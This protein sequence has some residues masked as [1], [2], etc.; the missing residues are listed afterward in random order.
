MRL[1]LAHLPGSRL[2]GSTLLA[3]ATLA[4][5]TATQSGVIGWGETV[6]NSAWTRDRYQALA[7]GWEHTLGLRVDGTLVAWGDNRGNEPRTPIGQCSD[8]PP[9][10]AG[11]TYIAASGGIRH[12]AALRSD[13]LILVWGDTQFEPWPLQLL[14]CVEISAGT[15]HTLARFTDGSVTVGGIDEPPAPALPAGVVYVEISAGGHHSLARH[16]D[17][18]VVAWGCNS[19]GQLDV[20]ALPPGV[21]YTAIA[22]DDGNSA[23]C[24][25]DGRAVQWGY[26]QLEESEQPADPG[27]LAYVEVAIGRW[28]TVLRRSDGV[29][30]GCGGPI[31]CPFPPPPAG[32]SYVRS[33]GDSSATVRSSRGARAPTSRTS[34][35][36][37]WH[38]RASLTST[39]RRDG[40]WST[41]CS[42]R[43]PCRPGRRSNASPHRRSTR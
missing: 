17:G 26:V 30:V 29:V 5:P 7:A 20:P 10:P 14:P 38:P 33:P 24:R 32:L 1:A 8:I 25:S 36:C 12:S 35:A 34:S 2:A 39:S 43:G 22:A 6:T 18:D 42:I 27:E 28:H 41:G 19:N 31:A 16:S 23:A 15:W 4:V 11:L 13:G 40:A 9:L 21:T 37:P 3:T